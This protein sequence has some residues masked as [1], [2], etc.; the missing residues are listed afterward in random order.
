MKS[1]SLPIYDLSGKTTK[2]M[3]LDPAVFSVT[4]NPILLHQALTAFLANRRVAIAHTKDRADVRGGGRKPWRQK[5]TGN[6]RA[7]STRSPLWRGGGVT[8]GPRSDRNYSVRLPQK[9]RQA[10]FKMALSAK[11]LDDHITLISD[12]DKVTGKTKDWINT[13]HNLPKHDG[14]LLIVGESKHDLADRA[15]RNIVN[16]KYVSL[17]SLTLFDLIH[18]SELI[19]TTGAVTGLTQRLNPAPQINSEAVKPSHK[20]TKAAV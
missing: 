17:E 10:A 13:F 19:L 8:F 12:L 2:T 20:T 18:F 5:G 1:L 7:G 3:D 11:A 6:A 14:K 9:M 16:Q 15:I 4:P